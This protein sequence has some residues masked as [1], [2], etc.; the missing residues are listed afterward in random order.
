MLQTVKDFENVKFVKMSSTLTMKLKIADLV[1]QD[2]QLV[3]KKVMSLSVLRL[4]KITSQMVLMLPRIQPTVHQTMSSNTSFML[5][6]HLIVECVLI[7]SSST[8]R[9]KNVFLAQKR[10]HS[11]DI[12]MLMVN[13]LSVVM[14]FI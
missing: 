9:R 10:L 8:K 2:A 6:K 13:V 7:M 5:I 3:K 4:L 12:A 14:D 11:V 1:K